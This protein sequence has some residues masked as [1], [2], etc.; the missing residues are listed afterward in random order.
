M[1]DAVATLANRHNDMGLT[2]WLDPAPRPFHERPFTVMGSARFSTA[3]MTTIRDPV[4]LGLP[5]HL[6][7][8]D[9][10]MDSTD[11]LANGSLHRAIRE[12]M[13]DSG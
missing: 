13:R 5:P 8:L 6:G 10:Y 11:A 9:Q 7:A 3:L 2:D 4:V 12:W 1:V